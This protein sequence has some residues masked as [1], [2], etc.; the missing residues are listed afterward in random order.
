MEERDLVR[1]GLAERLERACRDAVGDNLRSITYF[2]PT[3]Y[4]QI[5]RRSDLDCGADLDE[6][7]DHVVAG[8]RDHTAY[9]KSE[10]GGYRYTLRVF[11]NGYLVRGT[12]ATR[13]VYVTTDSL[14]MHSAETVA[15]AV[16]DV[17]T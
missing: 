12:T 6:F 2:T 7:V 17:L 11:E 3:A 16:R 13:G 9:R 1:P 15:A 5:Y 10:L 8:F 14:T 4:E